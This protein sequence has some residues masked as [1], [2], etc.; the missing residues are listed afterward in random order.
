LLLATALAA[1]DHIVES[2]EAKLRQD[3]FVLREE[4]QQ[5]TLD[6][7]KEPR[8]L[9]DLIQGGYI[10]EIPKDPITGKAD[11]IPDMDDAGSWLDQAARNLVCAQP[12]GAD[13]SGRDEV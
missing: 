10:R 2:K 1:Q 12:I 8:S 11:W 6:K 5:Y 9:D 7:Q 4:I 13:R 3:L